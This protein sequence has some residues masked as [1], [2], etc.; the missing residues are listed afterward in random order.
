MAG[1][2]QSSHHCSQPSEGNSFIASLATHDENNI[3]SGTSQMSQHDRYLGSQSMPTERPEPPY[4]LPSLQEYGQDSQWWGFGS[5]QPSA[6]SLHPFCPVSPSPY[7]PVQGELNLAPLQFS[8]LQQNTVNQAP[9]QHSLPSSYLAATTPSDHPNSRQRKTEEDDTTSFREAE[10]SLSSY[11]WLIHNGGDSL[12][13]STDGSGRQIVPGSY[14]EPCN[15]GAEDRGYGEVQHHYTEQSTVKGL[16]ALRGIESWRPCPVQG[17]VCVSDD[18]Y[19]LDSMSVSLNCRSVTDKREAFRVN[20]NQKWNSAAIENARQSQG[21]ILQETDTPVDSSTSLASG[22]HPS[23]LNKSFSGVYEPFVK[24]ADKTNTGEFNLQ[25]KKFPRDPDDFDDR[26]PTF[27]SSMCDFGSG[28]MHSPTASNTASHLDHGSHSQLA[29][30]S[31]ERCNICDEN[32]SCER[33]PAFSSPANRRR[34][35]REHHS[36]SQRILFKCLLDDHGSPCGIS[37]KNARYRKK[38]VKSIHKTEFSKLPPID[39]KHRPNNET[40]KMLD[41][42]F[43]KVQTST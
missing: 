32:P 6:P 21:Q 13:T 15:P 2:P 4:Q 16:N 22:I 31:W 12:L 11:D 43:A 3:S 9:H 26:S 14:M 18:Y 28:N 7:A 17:E 36:G 5:S 42:W 27:D 38:H 41:K 1:I 37:V 25:T 8:R 39:K 10:D 19:K 23:L 29:P 33:K 24:D 34:H 20:T 40:D 35:M 30:E